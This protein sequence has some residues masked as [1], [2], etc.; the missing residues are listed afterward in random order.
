[1]NWLPYS[2]LAAAFWTMFHVGAR[3]SGQ[4]LNPVLASMV[5]SV[6]ALAVALAWHYFFPDQD[7][8]RRSVAPGL[9]IY[10]I[11]MGL[12]AGLGDITYVILQK[13]APHFAQ[14]APITLILLYLFLFAA[15]LLLF[16]DTLNA[17]RLAGMLLGILSL[18][19]LTL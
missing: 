17:R 6:T 9:W 12:G 5:A 1:M 7:A 2:L 4:S 19:L 3:L 10:A 8:T 14:A 15:G 11:L 13:R 18:L 16:N